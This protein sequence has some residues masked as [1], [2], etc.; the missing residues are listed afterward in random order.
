MTQVFVDVETTGLDPYTCSIFQ[1]AGIIKKDDIEEKFNYFIRPYHGEQI[2]EFAS[3]KTGMTDEILSTYPPQEEAFKSFINLLNK[4][5]DVNDFNDRAF[6]IGYNSSFDSD[7]VREWFNYNNTMYASYFWFP[8]IDVMAYAAIVLI[9][10]RARLRNFQLATV[11][12]YMTGKLL[13]GA[14]DAFNDIEATRELLNILFKKNKEM[15][16]PVRAVKTS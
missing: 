4:Y 2:T 14:H 3:K 1:I 15:F 5:V 6:F 8:Y 9:G 13:T 16:I 12:K 10:E 7:F 11:Y